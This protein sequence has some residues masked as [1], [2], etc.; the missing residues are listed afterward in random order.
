MLVLP[1]VIDDQVHFREPGVT[2]KATIFTLS[3][4]ATSLLPDNVKNI[5]DTRK[6]ENCNL[7]SGGE[8]KIIGFLRVCFILSKSGRLNSFHSVN[9]NNA[10]AF[11]NAS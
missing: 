1:G 10:S 8:K 3:S 2:H 4:Y 11:S 9:N 5:S 6:V 7:L